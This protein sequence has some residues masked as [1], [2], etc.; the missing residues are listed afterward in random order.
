MKITQMII[1]FNS[2]LVVST[3][4]QSLGLEFENFFGNLGLL[5]GVT[6]ETPT[7]RERGVS[8]PA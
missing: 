1:S 2:L 6:F 7:K 5:E 8:L 4:Y 3:R